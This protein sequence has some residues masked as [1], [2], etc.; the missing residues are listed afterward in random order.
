MGDTK[1]ITYHPWG[2]FMAA[3]E[4]A[5]RLGDRRIGT[6]HLLLGLLHEP[7]IEALVGVSLDTAR[8][9][10]A[11]LDLESLR[12]IGIEH[13]PTTP[14]I[15]ERAVPNRPTARQVMTSRTKMTPAAKAALK[16]AGRPMRRGHQIC[17]QRVLQMLLE[18]APPDPAATL[19]QA[20]G[21]DRARL[22][23]ELEVLDENA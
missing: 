17:P 16:Q 10:L 15:A 23:S 3:R 1:T 9:A 12:A 22:R 11:N 5:R 8:E 19:L 13:V 20:L 21:A 7:E 4:E 6:D 14:P 18:N 2:T